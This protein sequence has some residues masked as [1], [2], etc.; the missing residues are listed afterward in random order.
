M[1][2]IEWTQFLEDGL[3]IKGKCCSMTVG[4]FDGVHRG[5][6]ALIERIV[7]HNK[8]YIPV[9]VTFRQNHKTIN[10]EQTA[11]NNSNEQKDILAFQERLALFENL[12][13]Q[14]TIV[15]EFTENFKQLPGFEFLE[16]LLKHGNVG[17]FAVGKNFRCGYQ[18]DTDAA[19]IKNFFTSHGIPVE[20][21]PEIMEGSLP[22]SSS[23]IRTA[24][25]EGDIE[26]ARKMLGAVQLA[27]KG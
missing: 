11:V 26:L 6:Q 16:L 7:S 19:S 5:H 4:I 25:A 27:A 15:I 22:V 9:V 13:V 24:I 18:L 14:I 2:V 17:F 8:N 10:S 3:K 12:G 23:R 20:V 21:V 1:Q